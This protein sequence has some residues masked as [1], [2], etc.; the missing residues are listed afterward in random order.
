[1][2]ILDSNHTKDHVLQ[3]LEAYH[4]LISPCSYVV[5]TDGIMKDLSDAPQGKAEWK[6]DNPCEAAKE[7]FYK[8]TPTLK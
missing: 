2:I 1:M 5:V 8:N 3:E 6:F 4:E 7:S